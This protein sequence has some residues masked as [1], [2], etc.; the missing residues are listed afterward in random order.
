MKKIIKVLFVLLIINIFIYRVYG[1]EN[2]ENIINTINDVN[3]NVIENTSIL[4][5]SAENVE[6]NVI[7]QIENV[8][9]INNIEIV[10]VRNSTRNIITPGVSYEAHVEDI[11]W[12]ELKENEEIAGTT[13]QCKRMEAIKINLIGLDNVN[14]KYQV[15][16]QDIG[17]M[18]WKQD[19]ELAGTTGEAK[20]AEAIRIKLDRS[21]DYSIMYRVHVEDIGWMDWKRDGELAGTTG[22]CKRM[23]AIQIKLINKEKRG[24]LEIESP[25]KNYIIYNKENLKISGWKMANTPNAYIKVFVDETE[26]DSENI[27]YKKRQDIINKIEGYGDEVDNPNPGFVIDF[28]TAGYD[29]N[30]EHILKIQLFDENGNKLDEKSTIFRIDNKDMHITYKTHVQDIGWQDYVIENKMAGTTGQCKR[31]EATQIKLYNAPTDA[32]VLYRVHVEDIGWMDWKKDDEIA[33]TTG[34]CKRVEAI[35]I[36]LEGMENYTVEYQVHVEDIGWTDWYID[37]ETAGTTGQ[38]KRV[39]AVRIRIVQNYKRRYRGIDVSE[40]NN[41]INWQ[42]IKNSGIDYV[43]I[44]VGFRGY[45]TSSDGTY[46]KKQI[47]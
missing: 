7:T 30:E 34:Q 17:W 31:V 11:G 19:G 14:I 37:G 39:E 41:T 13:G 15:H 6:N 28:S 5:N 33:G 24:T 29:T 3:E 12:M 36:K 45:G 2:V 20:R 8:E 1:L 10:E 22:Q 26:I 47:M 18:N 9:N 44:R 23:E 16:V 46:G 38:C 42:E 27:N 40:F 32:K 35:Q 25:T 43:M 4:E 21:N